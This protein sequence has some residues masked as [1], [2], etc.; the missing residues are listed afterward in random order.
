MYG[1][2]AFVGITFVMFCYYF[3]LLCLR[4]SQYKSRYRYQK[5]ISLFQGLSNSLILESQTTR[6]S[7]IQINCHS[8]QIQIEIKMLQNFL[9]HNMKFGLQWRFF[10]FEYV[11]Y[12]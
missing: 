7:I 1:L 5:H 11:E 6:V 8:N 12:N 3:Y 9:K 2:L 10:Y 4:F